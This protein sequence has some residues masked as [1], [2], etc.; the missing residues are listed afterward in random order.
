MKKLTKTKIVSLLVVLLGP[1]IFF[2]TM[3]MILFNVS[4]SGGSCDVS[5]SEVSTTTLTVSSTA[6][7]TDPFQKGT[8]ANQN[9]EK[10]VNS[11]INVGL[12]GAAANGMAGW[13]NSEGGF[14]MFGRAEGHYGNDLESNSIAYGNKPVGL[15]YYTHEA[16]GGTYQITPYTK[17]APLGDPKWED[18]DQMNRWVMNQVKNGDWVASMDLTGG[19]HSFEQFAQMTDVKQASLVWQAYER[20]SVAHINQQ[21]KQDDAQKF[22][23]LFNG[24]SHSYDEAKFKENF[25]SSATASGDSN[26]SSSSESSSSSKC[27]SSSSNGGA[28]GDDGTGSVNYKNFNAW[29]ADELPDDLKQ[30]AI[31]PKSLGLQFRLKEGWDVIAW[32][33]GQCTDLS[34]SLMY[35]LWQKDGNHPSQRMGDG[36]AVV[37]NW[38]SAFGGSVENKPSA[39]AVFSSAPGTGGSGGAG[40]TGV[41]SHVFENGDYLI[42]EQ[43]FGSYSG[44]DGGFGAYTWNYRYVTADSDG[45]TFYSPSQ[46][47]Y[48]V[49]DNAKTLG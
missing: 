36:K 7:D 5:S 33:G 40:H 1:L 12:S 41:V 26:S 42:V 27:G 34:A 9:A 46:A 18:I 24:A 6:S 10:L 38:V 3:I 20:G 29:K 48:S 13:I 47:G 28:W 31:D 35:A 49:V 39:G 14:V 37:G 4:V 44:D 16:G 17:Y 2:V 15:A 23:D 43:N 8:K 30:Y 22:Y 45:Y 32:S 25:G 21:Q 11:W 19:N